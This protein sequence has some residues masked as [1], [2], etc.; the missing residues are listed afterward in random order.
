LLE[1]IMGVTS[2]DVLWTHES[3]K[4]CKTHTDERE[5]ARSDLLVPRIEK[6]LEYQ[7]AGQYVSV[8]SRAPVAGARAFA[9]CAAGIVRS[10]PVVARRG[11]T[12]VG[13]RSVSLFS[14]GVVGER[15]R[16]TP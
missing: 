14:S 4:I 12:A 11:L 9:V 1:A 2:C 15:Y 5:P 8:E 10:S 6:V 3:A 13:P 16:E 7:G